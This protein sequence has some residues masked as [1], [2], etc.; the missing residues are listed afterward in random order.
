MNH[1]INKFICILGA[2]GNDSSF[3]FSTGLLCVV[4]VRQVCL[5]PCSNKPNKASSIYESLPLKSF[6]IDR[7]QVKE[8]YISWQNKIDERVSRKEM[9]WKRNNSKPWTKSQ[10][11]I[12]KKAEDFEIGTSL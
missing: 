6:N 2:Y 1:N 12:Q 4:I 10:F 5:M 3:Y 8:N 9:H 7:I 11:G